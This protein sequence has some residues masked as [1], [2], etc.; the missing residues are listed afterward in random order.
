MKV[1][2]YGEG[3]PKTAQCTQ[4][5]SELEYNFK[6]TN[7]Y[8]SEENSNNPLIHHLNVRVDYIRCPV[9]GNIIWIH[10]EVVSEEYVGDTK[11]KRWW[12]KK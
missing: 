6:D 12:Q 5:L 2:K 4:C 10:K 3:Y 11:K 9:C 1:L 8:I 7:F